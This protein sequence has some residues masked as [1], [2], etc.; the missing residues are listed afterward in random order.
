MLAEPEQFDVLILGGGPAGM[1]AALW[2]VDLGLRA[3]LF[4]KSGKLGGQ[5]ASIYNPIDNYLG[6]R[7]A[8]GQQML[9]DFL[10]SLEGREFDRR[11]DVEVD[12]IDLET[13]TV[14]TRG[15]ELITARS[16]VIA[17]G[18]RRRELNIAGEK[19]FVGRGI[20]RS[21]AESREHVGG[22]VVLIVGGGDAA[23][24][25]ALI[26][27]E[28]AERVIVVHR[29][30]NP[31]ARGEFVRELAGRDNVQFV[32][33]TK[34]ALIHGNERV[35]DVR[36][37]NVSSGIEY[38][39]PVDLVLVRIGVEPNSE[40]FLGQIDHDG[41]GFIK[42]DAEAKTSISGVYAIGDV[43]NRVSPTISTAVGM[44]A[45]A[46]KSIAASLVGRYPI[47]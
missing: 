37:S 45:T 31:S 40:L 46:V 20:L 8:N 11:L 38:D 14:L 17:T 41:N 16:I 7:A 24:E 9:E 15:Q 47:S 27:S 3:M 43:A 35:T 33:N 28:K 1:A 25:N 18:V 42:V 34:L 36:L 39:M 6:L 5:L 4:E 23:L 26:L 29:R 19:E 30:A 12:A 2:C 13:K 32:P 10:A 22:Q 21:G 44:A